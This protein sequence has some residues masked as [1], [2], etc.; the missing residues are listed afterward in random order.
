MGSFLFTAYM[1]L[2]LW[3]P[4]PFTV[5]PPTKR[6]VLIDVVLLLI[7]EAVSISILNEQ[8]NSLP[9]NRRGHRLGG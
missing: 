6:A 5:L 2:P 8:F 7:A 3:L 9:L 4:I 1:T